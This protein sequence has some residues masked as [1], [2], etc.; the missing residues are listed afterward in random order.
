[1]RLIVDETEVTAVARESLFACAERAGLHIPTS[2]VKQGKCR[3]CLV[4][5][6]AGAEHLSEPT[7]EESHL[8]GNFRLAC[9]AL[10]MRD[11]EVRCH[12]LRRNG[13]QIEEA[14]AGA[15]TSRP[16]DPIVERVGEAAVR[17]GDVIEA[18]AERILGLA[19]DLG[20][21]TVVV[22]LFDL[23]SGARLATQAFENP[24]RFGGSDVIA[25]IH[26]D[27]SHKGRLLQRTLL[28]YL[29]R[30]INALPCANHDIFEMTVAANTTMRDLMFGLDVHSVGQMPYRSITEH[31]LLSGDVETTSLSVPATTL[32]LPLH[33]RA[34]VYGLPV[35]G[36]HVG[37]DA[38]A[39]LLAT[40]LADNDAVSVLMDI[41]TNT[42]L[43]MGNRERLIA[44]SCP[45]GPAFEGG[46]LSC[47]VPGLEG[48]IEHLAIDEQG[49][50][51]CQVIGGGHPVGICGS[52]LID[53]LSE[54]R[55]TGRMNAQGRLADGDDSFAIGTQDM[56]LTEFD[57]NELAQAKGANT[58]GLMVALGSFGIDV[59]NVQTFYL[60]GGFG[61]HVDVAAAQ[62]IGLLPP[63][64]A[65]HFVKVGN[66]SLHGAA[67]V[68]LSSADRQRLETLVRRV[69]HIQLET[70]PEFFN[71]FVDGCQFTALPGGVDPLP[72]FRTSQP[73]EHRRSVAALARALGNPAGR[74]LP[75]AMLETIDEAYAAYE[76]HGQPWVWS[77]A[78]EIERI[79]D[80]AFV[81]G[82]QP[83]RSELLARRYAA[84]NAHAVVAMAI[85][86]GHWVD[87]EA[88]ALWAERPDLAL[89]L[90]RVAAT[91]V[92]DAMHSMTVELC[93]TAEE[94]GLCLLP[95]YSPGY[96]GWPM[97]DQHHIARLLRDDGA[98]PSESDLEL[99]ESGMVRPKNAQLSLFALSRGPA[100]E[101]TRAFHPCESCDLRGCRFRRRAYSSTSP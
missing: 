95:P 1:M 3:E 38:A 74:P 68:L 58:A 20:T 71:H 23:E 19:V 72:G 29:G 47:G 30:A 43:V 96:T 62:S 46:G 100:D 41:G 17:N 37:A 61:T 59:R 97:D 92:Q 65:N 57:I 25:R 94:R 51:E 73:I 2:C 90:D 98:G 76:R 81:A 84:A 40:G 26:F 82:G 7:R 6:E 49:R 75:S 53:L 56:R 89:A 77:R 12:T 67:M 86:G 10:L 66:A 64:P 60:A 55:R 69:E 45:A 79:D 31:Q 78:V 8:Q 63:L 22:G 16:V 54:L 4:E 18:H 50:T 70:D 35:I 5:I 85:S 48:A 83:F 27:T 15:A 33:E 11:G 99:L 101:T 28:G 93:K 87:G 32:R 44:A 88:E 21:T 24:Q 14:F 34:M 80:Q 39:C 52:G 9:R 36:S 91:V 13:L 42:E